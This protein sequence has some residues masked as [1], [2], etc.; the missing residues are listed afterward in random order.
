[1]VLALEKN[2]T[3]WLYNVKKLVS[4]TSVT[5]GGVNNDVAT[6]VTEN[7]HGLLVGDQV[8]VYGANPIIYNGTFLVT[9]RD[10]ETQFQYQLPQ[11]AQ[12]IPQGNIPIS[13]DLNKGKSDNAAVNNAIKSYTTNVQNS[14]FNDNYVYIAST[15]IPNYNIGP[16]PGSAFLPGNQRK[17][18]RFPLAPVT[19]STKDSISPGPIGTWVNGVS[20]WSYKS[21]STKTFG[22]VTSIDITNRGENYDA[23]TPPVITISGGGGTGA[24]ANVVVDGSLNAITV[25]EG[26]SRIYIISSCINCWWRRFWSIC[27]CYYH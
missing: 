5:Y 23:A 26:G 14:F 24:T 19:I 10:N 6:I 20:I 7:P 1:M 3:T 2:F 4:V 22:S 18:N 25:N 15:G 21:Q 27:N 13:V 12:V 9:S 16:F 8:T 11:P 17:L